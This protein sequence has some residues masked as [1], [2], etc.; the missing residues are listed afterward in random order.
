MLDFRYYFEFRGENAF[1]D[2]CANCE[3]RKFQKSEKVKKNRFCHLLIS[4]D[5]KESD[6]AI[7]S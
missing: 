2:F 5:I 1:Y 3:L 6:I 4:G 7:V